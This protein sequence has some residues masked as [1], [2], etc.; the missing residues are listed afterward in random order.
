MTYDWEA[1]SDQAWTVPLGIGLAKT[2]IMGKTPIKMQAQ[3]FYN[4]EQPDAFAMDWGFKFS[5]SPVVAN[6]FAKLLN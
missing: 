6:P 5:L 4:V 2:T 3:V 1:D